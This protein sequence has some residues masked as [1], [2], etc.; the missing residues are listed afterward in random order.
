MK[1][2]YIPN[3]EF[4]ILSIY[5]DDFFFSL[6]SLVLALSFIV[7][8]SVRFASVSKLGYTYLSVYVFF[9]L[10]AIWSYYIIVDLNFTLLPIKCAIIDPTRVMKWNQCTKKSFHTQIPVLFLELTPSRPYVECRTLFNPE[11]SMQNSHWDIVHESLHL[12][13]PCRI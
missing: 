3:S 9:M 13:D 1:I 4:R 7:Q 8:H 5:S 6:L 10:I 11:R 12:I 2:Y